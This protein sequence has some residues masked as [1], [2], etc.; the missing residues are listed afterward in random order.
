MPAFQSP[1]NVLQ[2]K[3]PNLKLFQLLA[4]HLKPAHLNLPSSTPLSQT[5]S[6]FLDPA[7]KN[8]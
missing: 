4:L 6:L 1:Q 5:A 7:F 8:P 2:R 3:A